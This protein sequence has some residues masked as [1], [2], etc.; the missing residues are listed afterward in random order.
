MI[1]WYKTEENY[2]FLINCLAVFY[3]VMLQS[4]C[5]HLQKP[6]EDISLSELLQLLSVTESKIRFMFKSSLNTKLLSVNEKFHEVLT[7]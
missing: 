6:Q 1:R 4:H 2:I 3:V 5:D 7:V